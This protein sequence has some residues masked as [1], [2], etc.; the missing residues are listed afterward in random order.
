MK[1][2]R[3][4]A[5][6]LLLLAATTVFA[7]SDASKTFDQLKSLSGMWE[8]KA[9]DGKVVKV[10]FRSTAGGSALVS[11]ILGEGPENMIT[12]FHM[13]NSRVL[14]THYCGAG[15]QPRMQATAS[16]DG[17][18]ITFNFVDATN[19]SSPKAGHMAHLVI[20]MADAEHHSQDWT[21]VQDGK[22]TKEHFELTRSKASL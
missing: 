9:P 12:M 21:F 15:N 5:T 19:L 22:E 14:M 8:G 7:Q 17:K 13:D 4:V 18:T 11:E 16:P 6:A 1:S 3:T 20:T 10:S 2:I